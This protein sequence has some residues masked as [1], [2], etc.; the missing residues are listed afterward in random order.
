MD[1]VTVV[2]APH[3]Y[4]M[5]HESCARV[6]ESERRLQGPAVQKGV[7]KQSGKY[8]APTDMFRKSVSHSSLML[9]LYSHHW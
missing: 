6:V 1:H 8:A 7:D 5:S 2:N 9:E 3:M 4:T